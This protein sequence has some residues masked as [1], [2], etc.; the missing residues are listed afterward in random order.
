MITYYANNLSIVDEHL[1]D[2]Y[3]VTSLDKKVVLR[4]KSITV[5]IVLK[6]VAS[7]ILSR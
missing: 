3:I 1:C 2:I 6:T 5:R 4:C 7:L